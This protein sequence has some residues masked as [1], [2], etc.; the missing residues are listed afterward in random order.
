LPFLFVF[1][2]LPHLQQSSKPDT[3]NSVSDPWLFNNHCASAADQFLE[4]AP[5]SGNAIANL[6]SALRR[7]RNPAHP[8][9]DQTEVVIQ[10][11][12]QEDGTATPSQDEAIIA[13]AKSAFRACLVL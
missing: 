10:L 4:T 9:P 7:R 5:P 6:F 3:R 2:R 1:V 11:S 12:A 8:R 13:D